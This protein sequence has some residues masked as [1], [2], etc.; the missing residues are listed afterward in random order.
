MKRKNGNF[1]IF[2][3]SKQHHY[4]NIATVIHPPAALLLFIRPLF[5]SPP[6]PRTTKCDGVGTKRTRTSPSSNPTPHLPPSLLHFI[7]KYEKVAGF[8]HNFTGFVRAI[9]ATISGK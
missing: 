8:T 5:G 4:S 3:C 7:G 1:K 2:Y 9:P 6:P